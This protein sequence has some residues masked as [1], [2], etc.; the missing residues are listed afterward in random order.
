MKVVLC[1]VPH[2]SVTG[3]RRSA[4]PLWAGYLHAG[5]KDL[6][7]AGRI[8]VSLIDGEVIDFGATNLLLRS[9][10]VNKIACAFFPRWAVNFEQLRQFAS[11]PAHPWWEVFLQ[12]LMAEKPDVVAITAFTNNIAVIHTLSRSLKDACPGIKILVGGI[13]PTA[14]QANV[15]GHLPHVDYF[16]IGEGEVTFREFL[17]A[18]L[19]GGDPGSVPGILPQEDPGKYRPRS[20]IEDIDDL[21]MPTRTLDR[22][23]LYRAEH[24]IF[25]SRG[26]PY[27]CNFCSS[28]QMWSR[29]VRYHSVERVLAEMQEIRELGGDRVIFV[30]DTFT[31]NRKRVL[32][33]MAAFEQH[34]FS[35]MNIHVGARINTLDQ[36]L[37]DALKRGGVKSMSFG[38]ETGS[39]RIQEAS[40]KKL[41]RE[42]IVDI[43]KYV[44]S[45]GIH[46]LTYFIVGH[47]GE[48]EED[49][50]QTISLMREIGVGK[51]SVCSMQPLPGTDIYAAAQK[52]GFSIDPSNALKMEQLGLPA[53]NLSEMPDAVLAEKVAEVS[54]VANRLSQPARL[55]QATDYYLGKLRRLA[56]A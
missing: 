4:Y 53:V 24:H 12:R 27:L 6:I 30:D 48:T 46:I 7:D 11:N 34:G 19:E 35:D 50:A 54:G 51:I 44:D 31:L 1:R 17:L 15:R 25:S 13:H 47:P 9:P 29:K 5:V 56:R 45:I 3:I 49:V 43:L 55:R 26:C 23:E 36:E 16:C 37:V 18:Q 22:G 14:D 28:Y 10:L 21:P 42:D 8:D 20:M 41:K 40:H 2:N 33:L 39:T 32:A 38:L 52:R